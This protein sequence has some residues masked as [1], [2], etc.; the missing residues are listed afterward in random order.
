MSRYYI[1]VLGN[2]YASLDRF[3]LPLLRIVLGLILIPHGAQKLFGW[4]G[5]DS[6]SLSS[7]STSLATSPAC[8]G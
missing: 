1:P 8:S 2:L 4:F 7:C 3:M 6:P 5:G